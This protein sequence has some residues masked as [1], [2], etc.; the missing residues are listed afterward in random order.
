MTLLEWLKSKMFGRK[1]ITRIEGKPDE[2]RLT[3]INNDQEIM[4]SKLREYDVWYTGDSGE[5]LNFYTRDNMIDANYEPFYSRNR[6]NY[7]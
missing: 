6:I 5:L 2:D 4:L 3:F 1:G 7:F